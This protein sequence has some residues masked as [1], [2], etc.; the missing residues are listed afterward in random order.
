MTKRLLI[1]LS[2]L[3]LLSSSACNLLTSRKPTPTPEPPPPGM[4]RYYGEGMSI[5]LPPSFKERNVQEDLPAVIDTIK[6][7][8]GGED[9]LLS[10][11]LDNIEKNVAWW[12]W[13]S[14]TL[15][16]SPLYLLVIKNKALN[17]IPLTATAIGLERLLNNE[18]AQVEQ[19]TVHL[20]G[21]SMVR[22]KFVKG[23]VA[24]VAY[25]FK[26]Q[27][28]LWLSLFIF[29]PEGLIGAQSSF[30][31]SMGTITIDPEQSEAN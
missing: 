6:K 12:V 28:H 16:E 9:G 8:T 27:G 24:W 3:L 30:D 14:E 7:F 10:G 29:T 23:E 15:E 31:S 22:F 4:E 11:L 21:R 20:G 26:E 1:L 17:S 18:E 13:D 2:V 19:S 5:M 25:A